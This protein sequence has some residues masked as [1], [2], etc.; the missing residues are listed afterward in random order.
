MRV[1]LIED[2]VRLGELIGDGL[3]RDGFVVDQRCSL[4]DAVE[5][6]D[7]G[8]YDLLLLDLGL[9]DGDGLDLVRSLRRRKISTPILIL[10]ARG[11]LSDRVTGLYVGADDYLVKPFEMVELSARCRALLRRPCGSLGVTLEAGN[12]RLDTTSRSLTVAGVEA[13]MPPRET[14]LLEQLLRRAGQVVPKSAL[15]DQLYSMDDEV[16]P[17]ALEVA[18]SRLRRRL[19]NVSA[20]VTVRTAYGVGYALV[21][22]MGE[23]LAAR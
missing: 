17:N 23:N 16:T 5:A 2:N 19:A 7:F 22:T 10:T 1:L 8:G 11:G 21:S 4:N 12:V 13:H 6:L 9:P 20:D 14:A 15:E 3:R 18:A